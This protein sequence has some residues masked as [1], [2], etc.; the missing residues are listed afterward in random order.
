MSQNSKNAI[1]DVVK[2]YFVSNGGAER[3]NDEKE[4]KQI[5]EAFSLIAEREFQDLRDEKSIRVYELLK[6][7]KEA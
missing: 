5:D 3:A 1:S 6:K 4:T 7:L 2:N